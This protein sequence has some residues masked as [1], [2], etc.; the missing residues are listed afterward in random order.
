MNNL[1]ISSFLKQHDV[2]S[3]NFL[4]VYSA[5]TLPMLNNKTVYPTSLISNTA[6][7]GYPG[8][9]WIAMWLPCKG[10]KEYFDS[11]GL[12]PFKKMFLSFLNDN[13]VYNKKQLQHVWSAT[14]GQYCIY[15]IYYKCKGYS[16]QK[17]IKHFTDN[18]KLNDYK[19]NKFVEQEWHSDLDIYDVSML[20]AQNSLPA[21]KIL[22]IYNSL[23]KTL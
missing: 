1:Q 6:N 21:T 18:T 7:F 22:H 20:K 11:Y 13:F 2:T 4:G 5:D 9:H 10:K 15:Y 19:V 16:L 23:Q 8:E 3:S 14:C 12:P 17:I